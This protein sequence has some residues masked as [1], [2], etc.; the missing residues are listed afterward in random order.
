[1]KLKDLRFMVMLPVVLLTALNAVSDNQQEIQQLEIERHLDSVFNSSSLVS[2]PYFSTHITEFDMKTAADTLGVELAAIKAVIEI[3]AGYAHRGIVSPGIPIVFFQRAV[4][5]KKAAK[6][7][8][9]LTQARK[10]YPEL[11]S[12]GTS[13][14]P[15]VYHHYDLL[16]KAMKV[17]PVAAVESTFWGMFQIGGFNWKRCGA[18]SPEEFAFRMSM[19][20]K[21]QFRFFIK[22]IQHGGMLDSMRQKNWTRFAAVYN[23]PG[24]QRRQYHVRL[25]EAYKKHKSNS[26]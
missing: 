3:E 10:L 26:L 13:S 20:E 14:K 1:M 22:F 9:D 15:R 16:Q 5:L 12:T 6:N 24:Y 17:D 8:S 21:E 4:F 25:A 2:L 19:S 18:G 11:F 23:G 7:N